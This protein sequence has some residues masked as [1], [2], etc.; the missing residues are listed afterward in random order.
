LDPKFEQL[1]EKFEPQDY[2]G[3]VNNNNSTSA[4]GGREEKQEPALKQKQLQQEEVGIN[5][6]DN[7]KVGEIVNIITLHEKQ[8]VFWQVYDALE[9]EYASDPTITIEVDKLTVSGEKLKSRL[10]SSGQFV[11]GQAVEAIKYMVNV[12]KQLEQV[13]FDTY[14]KVNK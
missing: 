4:N 10:V 7:Q 12:T 13:S 6:E 3:Y 2:S 9:S 11:V 5:I 14:K 8:A 1:R